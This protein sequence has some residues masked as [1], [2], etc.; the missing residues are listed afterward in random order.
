MPA[1]DI[2]LTAY[3]CSAQA[4]C[5][6]WARE[7][8]DEEPIVLAVPGSGGNFLRKGRQW[9][10]TGDAFRAALRELAPQYRDVEV[11]RRALVTFSGGWQL[12][13]NLLLSEREQQLL[14]ACIL[15][16]GLHSDEM[17]HW[18]N[19]AKRAANGK[20]WMMMAHS[21]VTP[22]YVSSKITNEM[23]FNRAI[24]EGSAPKCLELPD[25]LLNAM[26]PSEGIRIPVASVKDATGRVVMPAQTKI[27]DKD[28][29]VSWDNRGSLYLLEYEGDDRPDPLYIA[30]VTAPRLWRMLADHWNHPA[31]PRPA[32]ARTPT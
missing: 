15:E 20:A 25:Y 4:P 28:C 6:S 10:A 1:R 17:D 7:M 2:I 8:F 3:A 26:L 12:T 31:G 14:D 19:F 5:S 24:S 16:E 18:V 23:V 30:W 27:W 32:N 22:P 29:L 9:S 13:H 21:Q 11:R